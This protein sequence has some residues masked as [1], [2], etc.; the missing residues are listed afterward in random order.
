MS[1]IVCVAI[2]GAVQGTPWWVW[3]IFAEVLFI[4]MRAMRVHRIYVPVLFIVPMVLVGLNYKIYLL[5]YATM[6][7]AFF[8][9][10]IGGSV[11]VFLGNKTPITVLRP[12][13]S[14]EVQGNYHTLVVLIIVFSIQYAFGYVSA[15]APEVGLRY[16]GLRALLS[17]LFLGYFLGRTTSYVYRFATYKLGKESARETLS[18]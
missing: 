3:A 12:L 1:K 11:G 5:D 9:L 4:G 16:M 10:V 13:K 2:L 15:T 14:I 6:L 17:A 18:L 7:C 8:S